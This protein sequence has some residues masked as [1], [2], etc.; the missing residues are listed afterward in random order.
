MSIEKIINSAWDQKD[1]INPNS[2]KSLKDAI[3]HFFDYI[4]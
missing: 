4:I 3:N 1:K 2:D